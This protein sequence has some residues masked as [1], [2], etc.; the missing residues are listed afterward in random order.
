[1]RGKD[2]EWLAETFI[3]RISR[4]MG[5]RLEPLTPDQLRLLRDY[6]WPGNVREL[7]NVVE[8]AIILASGSRIQLERAMTGSATTTPPASSPLDT[9]P[10]PVPTRILTSR[11][12]LDLERNN[13]IRALASCDW[14][15]SGAQGAAR[16]LG[17]PP[18]TLGSR[19]KALG[20]KRPRE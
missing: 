9:S 4:R 16:L 12:W 10:P 11:E 18:T 6:D 19:M 15:I 8:R 17:L 14:R 20:I 1:D 13:L 7:Q 3:L 2:I 5:K